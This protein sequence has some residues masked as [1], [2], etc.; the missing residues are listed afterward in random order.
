MYMFYKH[1]CTAVHVEKKTFPVL[2]HVHVEVC[3]DWKIGFDCKGFCLSLPPT[4]SLSLSLSL[5]LCLSLLS[6]SLSLSVELVCVCR[7]I[8]CVLRVEP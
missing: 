8:L 3:P 5:S 4:S 6:L 1:K 2:H 7:S